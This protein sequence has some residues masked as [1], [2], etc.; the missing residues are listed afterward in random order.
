MPSPSIRSYQKHMIETLF[1]RDNPEVCVF[2][3]LVIP[4][5]IAF[6]SLLHFHF[7]LYSTS[8]SVNTC[9]TFLNKKIKNPLFQPWDVKDT[10]SQTLYL[11]G[12]WNP[13]GSESNN[14]TATW[15]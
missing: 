2:S 1:I 14:R 13:M 15:Y 11:C 5:M 10:D 12:L 4:L 9:L 7:S 8:I 3:S 6:L